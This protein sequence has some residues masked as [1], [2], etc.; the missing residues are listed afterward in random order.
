MYRCLRCV[1]EICSAD[2]ESLKRNLDERKLVAE[3]RQAHLHEASSMFD[4]DGILER[5]FNSLTG[6]H[7]TYGRVE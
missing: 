7:S 2:D 6:T 3:E 4:D 5:I 1:S